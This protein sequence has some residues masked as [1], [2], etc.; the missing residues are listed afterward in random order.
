MYIG[1]PPNPNQKCRNNDQFGHIINN[2]QTNS[3]ELALSD[4]ESDFQDAD[5]DCRQWA[6]QF[7][8][9]IIRKP[10]PSSPTSD[11]T[12]PLLEDTTTDNDIDNETKPITTHNRE[13][14]QITK[15][16]KISPVEFSDEE[17]VSVTTTR[18][19]HVEGEETLLN[20]ANH[21]MDEGV[22]TNEYEYN[23]LHDS[24]SN[25]NLDYDYDNTEAT[26]GEVDITTSYPWDIANDISTYAQPLTS[27][28]STIRY[29][30]PTTSK[31]KRRRKYGN[32]NRGRK[33][34]I[35][36]KHRPYLLGNS[37]QTG[38][39][40]LMPVRPP[41]GKNCIKTEEDKLW[42][43]I[44]IV[45][46]SF[47]LMT[48]TI[49]TAVLMISLKKSSKLI[50]KHEYLLPLGLLLLFISIATMAVKPT[51]ELCTLKRILPGLGYTC[52][53]VGMLLQL[54]HEL[55]KNVYIVNPKTKR[56][57]CTFC[58]LSFRQMLSSKENSQ[59]LIGLCLTSIQ[60]IIIIAWLSVQPP[61]LL[62]NQCQC[63]AIASIQTFAIFSFVYPFILGL[64]VSGLSVLSL[65]WKTNSGAKWN[66][67]AILC[68]VVSWICL[69]MNVETLNSFKY[70][71]LLTH[72]IASVTLLLFVFTRKVVNRIRSLL[73]QTFSEDERGLQ[74]TANSSL[75][76]YPPARTL[77]PDYL[78]PDDRDR[79]IIKPT[80]GSLSM[81]SNPATDINVDTLKKHTML[82]SY[83]N[84]SYTNTY[85]SC[86][87]FKLPSVIGKFT[88][89]LLK[90]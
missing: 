21:P 53:F 16:N 46:S 42:L 71:N 50:L 19:N 87:S 39:V 3:T 51:Y 41:R 37:E 49:G 14:A 52:T 80:N 25:E 31:F 76:E 56:L 23:H 69:V 74:M 27:R 15:G 28:E 64:L 63:Q 48:V 5:C 22:H 45:V 13:L 59:I 29:E 62:T 11:I 20:N 75:P 66:L 58:G 65:V 84:R 77:T 82:H 81:R 57:D 86:G 67:F 18:D 44:A 4:E 40:E 85:S 47:G 73:Q 78:H 26:E 10:T 55:D 6:F 24:R 32:N 54:L 70:L 8:R 79:I 68:S 34:Y 90:R 61:R 30:D 35:S 1:G 83:V 43:V 60:I 36:P 38:S 2:F 89:A 17:I 72:V 12:D 88:L 33:R 9:P 7:L